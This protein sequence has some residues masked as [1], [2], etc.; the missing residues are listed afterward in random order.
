M[1]LGQGLGNHAI[2]QM[3][4]E[5]VVKTIQK[6]CWC[7]SVGDLSLLQADHIA[8]HNKYDE[9]VWRNFR[10]FQKELLDSTNEAQKI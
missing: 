1:K 7:A 10:F 9:K 6:I 4:D 2:K 3:P 5:T 8:I